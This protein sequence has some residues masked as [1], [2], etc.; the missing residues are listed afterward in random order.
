MSYARPGEGSDVYVW[1]DGKLLHCEAEGKTYTTT[2]HEEMW[3]HLR[4]HRR[5][6]HT[7]PEKALDRLWCEARGFPYETDVQAAM[8]TLKE[9]R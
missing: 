4:M 8:R 1:G 6:G 3:E 2:S 9:M 7:V 5:R